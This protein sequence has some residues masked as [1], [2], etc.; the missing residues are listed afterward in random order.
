MTNTADV[1]AA[2]SLCVTTITAAWFTMGPRYEDLRASNVADLR[3]VDSLRHAEFSVCSIALVF[4]AMVAFY[5]RDY[6]PVALT[7]LTL[8]LL[9]GM[10]EWTLRSTQQ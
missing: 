4:S 8:A 1:L 5:L 6:T 3:A 10:Y 2:S 9:I 7:V